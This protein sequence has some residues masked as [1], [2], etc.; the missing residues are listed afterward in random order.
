MPTNTPPNFLVKPTGKTVDASVS[1][2]SHVV[3]VQ[4]DGKIFVNSVSYSNN[5]LTTIRFNPNGSLDASY[6]G[7]GVAIT[8]L[9][10][11]SPGVNSAI[12]KQA[13]GKILVTSKYDSVYEFT[14]IRYNA[15]GSLD[16]SFS[17]D[18]KVTTHV[19]FNSD[20]YDYANAIT[21]QADDKIL[22][23]GSTGDGNADARHHHNFGLVRY[24]SNGSLDTRF[25]GDGKLT[26]AVEG[27]AEAFAVTVQAN[28]KILVAGEAGSST[29][30]FSDFAVVR[31]NANGTLDTGF[32]GDGKVTTDLGAADT[33]YAVSVQTNGKILLAG[34]SNGNFALVRYN[35]NGTL[36]TSFSGDGKVITD[37][38]GDDNASSV[39]VQADGKILLTGTSDG[40]VALVRYNADGSLDT[41]FGGTHTLNSNATYA[42]NKPAV[43]LDSSVNIFDAELNAQGHYAGAS[44]TL[45]RHGGANNQDVFS[46]AGK[47]SFSSGNAVLSGV[48]VGT[49]SNSAGKMTITFNSNATQ[50]RVDAVLSSISYK[51]T[52]HTSTIVKIDWRFDDGNTGTQGTGGA[53]A[54]L[55]FTDVNINTPALKTPTVMHYTDTALNDNFKVITGTLHSSHVGNKPLTY[56]IVNSSYTDENNVKSNFETYGILALNKKTGVY[57]FTPNAEA[58]NGLGADK[59]VRFTVT[60]TDGLLTSSTKIILNIT[61]HGATESNGNDTLAGTSADDVLNGLAG[62]DTLSGKKGD[63]ILWGGEGNDILIGNAGDD[64]LNGGAGKD[65]LYGHEGNDTL[66]AGGGDDTSANRYIDSLYGG[67]GND[68]LVSDGGKDRLFGGDG[69]D[70]LIGYD[71]DSLSGGNGNDNLIVSG[72]EGHSVLTGGLGKDTYIIDGWATVK[73]TDFTP[74]DDSLQLNN[75][76]FRELDTGRLAAKHFVIGSKALDND[77]FLIYNKNTGTLF[78]DADGIGENVPHKITTLGANLALTYADFV[79]T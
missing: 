78:Y 36:D 20:S 74:L 56:D 60:V 4:A 7:D 57:N 48:T 16:N 75:D 40:H 17:G 10:Y 33:A 46:G 2:D 38:G 6:S 43:V 62:D 32:S 69:N 27:Y 9:K 3:K 15:N 39:T 11:D 76:Y 12:F 45:A 49:V 35:A 26:T 54:A 79:V 37:L 19:N 44:V 8:H 14:L 29:S 1:V 71:G 51:N 58:I 31:Y 68:K 24:N 61:Q 18:G 63:D 66:N 42:D 47:L 25:S 50:A 28:G 70:T 5:N 72:Y 55:G 52:A 73:I 53:L 59:S 23:A 65:V 22:V 67:A 41:A 13:D 30:H 21:Q 34:S 77:D 64:N